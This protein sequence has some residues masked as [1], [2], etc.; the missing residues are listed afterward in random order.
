V[1]LEVNGV[2]VQID[3]RQIVEEISLQVAPGEI[4]GLIGP[5]GSGKSTLL[6][7]VYRLLKPAAGY[8]QLGSDDVWRLTA[9]IGTPY[10]RGSA[11]DAQRF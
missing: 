8:V 2:G 9:R 5:N 1:K 6:R 4:V 3:S 11:G 7:A 10:W